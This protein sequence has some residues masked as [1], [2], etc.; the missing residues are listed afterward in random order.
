M[1]FRDSRY[2]VLSK[3]II[4]HKT[5]G[6]EMLKKMISMSVLT[7]ATIISVQVFAAPA[8]PVIDLKPFAEFSY[9]SMQKDDGTGILDFVNDIWLNDQATLVTVKFINSDTE[10]SRTLV[11]I[12]AT[13]YDKKNKSFIYTTPDVPP[14]VNPS[15][16]P[17]S[18]EYKHWWGVIGFAGLTTNEIVFIMQD[19]AGSN[20]LLVSY[21]KNKRTKT[22]DRNKTVTIPIENAGGITTKLRGVWSYTSSIYYVVSSTDNATGEVTDSAIYVYDSK[23]ANLMKMRSNPTPGNLT[24]GVRGGN[25][26]LLPMT[27]GYIFDDYNVTNGDD[28]VTR[29]VNIYKQP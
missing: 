6:G 25:S 16:N 9:L 17:D 10:D 4:F 19:F 24:Y 3:L 27:P 1:R 11:G 28:S 29:H 26:S 2:A 23:L 15:T 8:A 18:S 21:T 13:F 14:L 20:T 12:S 5:G 22:L 7:L